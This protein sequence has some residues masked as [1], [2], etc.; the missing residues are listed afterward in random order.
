MIE[1]RTKVSKF[2]LLTYHTGYRIFN[3]GDYIQSIAARQFLPTV[4]VY[5]NREALHSYKG[6][7]VKVIMNGWFLHHPEH[8][9]PSE[10]VIPLF[11]SFHLSPDAAFLLDDPKNI[12]Y[13]KKHQPIGCR[14]Q[15]TVSLLRGKGI[16]AYFSG[17][18]TLTINKPS[19]NFKKKNIIASDVF[20]PLFSRNTVKRTV[21]YFHE[22]DSIRKIFYFIK[23]T[24]NKWVNHR[25][26]F[27]SLSKLIGKE[28]INGR[29]NVF[30]MQSAGMIE[31]ERF[32]YA[33]SLL[34]LYAQAKLV[35]TT[36]LHCALPCVA[37]GTPVIFIREEDEIEFN[38]SRFAG[39]VDELNTVIIPKNRRSPINLDRYCQ[40]PK[41]VFVEKELVNLMERKIA[42]F[43]K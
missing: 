10:N 16:D 4:D 13:F 22:L 43:I 39:L 7:P 18:L 36:R 33:E 6:D 19:S 21:S 25:Y 23:N 8:W 30:H 14:D 5:L 31:E 9:P 41:S 37:F 1:D 28:E 24:R 29:I 40:I 38:S 34:C 35:I 32:K 42:D 27:K 2:G 17:C 3:V 26:M 15:Y 11:I 20:D 12:V